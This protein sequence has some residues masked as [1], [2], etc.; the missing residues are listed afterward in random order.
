MENT[1][2]ARGLTVRIHESTRHLFLAAAAK[3]GVTVSTFIRDA[4]RDVALQKLSDTS[5]E[6]AGR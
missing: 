6:G 4:A 1:A 2:A 3:D 5:T